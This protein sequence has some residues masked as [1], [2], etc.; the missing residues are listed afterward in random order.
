MMK[1]IW[2]VNNMQDSMFIMLKKGIYHKETDIVS[3]NIIHLK[4]CLCGDMTR[5]NKPF[6][7]CEQ[8][9]TRKYIPKA[10]QNKKFIKSNFKKNKKNNKKKG[11]KK[12]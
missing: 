6:L 7:L 9:T 1:G 2:T 3:E 12:K 4:K 10:K 5:R 8:K 11:Q